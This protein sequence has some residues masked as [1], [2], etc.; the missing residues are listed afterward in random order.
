MVNP[1]EEYQAIESYTI[2]RYEQDY[3]L[4][5]D[6]NENTLGCSPFVESAIK[7]LSPA[8]F[9]K[10]P[11]YGEIEDKIANFFGLETSQVVVTNGGDAGI[12][13]MYNTYVNPE[14]EII[15]TV[16]TYVMYKIDAQRVR[17][18]IVQVPYEQKWIYPVDKVIEKVSNRTKLI[19]ISS[20]ANPTGDIVPEEDICKILEAAPDT[21]LLLDEAY[22]RFTSRENKTLKH[23]INK[24]DNLTIMHTFSKDYGLAG[25]RI[26]YLISKSDNIE[27]IR[28]SMDP[29]SVNIIANKAAMAAMDDQ[30]FVQ[31]YVNQVKESKEYVK[32]ELKNIADEVYDS[33]AN[34]IFFYVGY[35]QEW[36]HSKLIKKRI[37][38]RR[39]PNNPMLEGYIRLTL[40]TIDQ[41]KIVINHLK[42]YELI[43]FDIDGVLVDESQTYRKAIRCTYQYF[44]GKEI[45]F[46]KIQEY[47]NKGGFNNDWKLTR[48]LLKLENINITMDEV[49]NKFQEYYFNDGKGFIAE[50]TLLVNKELIKNLARKYKL[51]VF[52][53]RPR[54]EALYILSKEGIKN[55]F[56]I[57]ISMD[58]VPQGKGKPDPWGLEEICNKLGTRNAIYIGD[59][60]DDI[61]ASEAAN[62]DSAGILPPQDK[63]ESLAQLL[64]SKGAISVYD[65]A[66]EAIKRIFGETLT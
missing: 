56:D 49:I 42:D 51:A 3:I 43:I 5:L 19:V 54:S 62:L 46:E 30:D 32:N 48:H 20:P 10:Y 53:G 24:Y 41:M 23:L 65:N 9:S 14:D 6:M 66:S 16:P 52:T 36:Y 35:K 26:G 15:Y 63:S 1:K 38:L 50:E 55:C 27:Q 40:G 37:K 17:A 47:K 7:S 34:F 58:D 61:E 45:S 59:M 13:A 22:W 8:D 33:E 21:M 2:A 4:K 12:N 44:A 25:I 11:T 29:F 31:N 57:I 18:M 64:I 39:Y 60:P 28:K